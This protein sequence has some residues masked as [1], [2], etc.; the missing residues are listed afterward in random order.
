MGVASMGEITRG[1]LAAGMRADTPAAVL[2]QGTTPH[3]R[4]VAATLETLEEAAVRAGIGTP[5]IIVVGAVADLARERSWYERLP[6]FG[7]RFVLTRPTE[8]MEPLARKLRQVGAQVLEAPAITLRAKEINDEIRDAFWKLGDKQWDCLVFTSPAGVRIFFEILMTQ[9]MDSRDLSGCRIAV[10]GS[11]TASALKDRGLIADLMP[12]TYNG[13]SLGRLL[14][15]ELADGSRVLIPRSAIGNPKLVTSMETRGAELGKQ[16]VIRDL[17]IYET[18]T[19]H[20]Q[21]PMEELTGGTPPD[22]IFFTSASTVRAFLEQ[23]PG[24]P[25]AGLTALCMGEMTGEAAKA[26]GMNVMIA[27]QA[28]VDGLLALAERTAE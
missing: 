5:A 19:V 25:M 23:Y 2:E 20:E 6:L 24:L 15:E 14:G 28:T 11:G 1:L 22:G 8:R 16:F 12:E 4:R 18:E 21:I 17:A 7:K 26:A 3:Q 10:I 9:G 27:E 13:V